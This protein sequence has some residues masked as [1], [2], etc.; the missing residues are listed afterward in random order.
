MLRYFEI[1]ASNKFEDFAV[2]VVI[3]GLFVSTLYF[4]TVT[5]MLAM[6]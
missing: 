3:A 4:L 2:F 5:I 6:S 1:Q